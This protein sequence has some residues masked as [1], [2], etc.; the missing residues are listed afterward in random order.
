MLD[1]GDHILVLERYEDSKARFVQ[2]LTKLTEL[3]ITDFPPELLFPGRIGTILIRMGFVSEIDDEC[4]FR[5][6]QSS[7]RLVL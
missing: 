5:Y 6:D 7:L 3:D 4:F 1:S 2:D